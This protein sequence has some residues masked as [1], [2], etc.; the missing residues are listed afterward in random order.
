[1]IIRRK[2]NGD[3]NMSFDRADFARW[4]AFLTAF[5]PVVRMPPRGWWL[6]ASNNE[7]WEKFVGEFLV[8]GGT[9]LVDR[10]VQ[11]PKKKTQFSTLISLRSLATAR[12]PVLQLRRAMKMATRFWPVAA[13]EIER[14]RRSRKVVNGSRF[15]LLKNLPKA[16]SEVA[17]RDLVLKRC[18]AL[19]MKGASNFLINIG[20]AR[21]LAAIDTRIIRCLERHFSAKPGINRARSSKPL[22]LAVESALREVARI[23]KTPLSGLDRS[24]FQASGMS[25][26][27]F[28][29]ETTKA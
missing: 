3:W 5:K 29:L 22:Y 27:D 2:A 26:L 1:M 7:L 15:V 19:G 12:S 18:P 17:L 6:R 8:R 20:A 28:V 23:N 14:C 11:D 25:A 24:I 9:R 10:L 21:D 13:R 4:R 16:F